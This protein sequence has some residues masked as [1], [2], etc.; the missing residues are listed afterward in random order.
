MGR[1]RHAGTALALLL[2][3]LLSH[4]SYQLAQPPPGLKPKIFVIGLSKTGTTS[5]GDALEML[6]YR[7]LGWRD[8]R[9]Q[10]MVHT[11]VST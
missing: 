1:I 9:S 8:I 6:G 3:L 4:I 10:H 7:R 2:A 11:W 5:I